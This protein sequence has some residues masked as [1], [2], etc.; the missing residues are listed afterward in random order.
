MP[1]DPEISRGASPAAAKDSGKP[2]LFGARQLDPGAIDYKNIP[3]KSDVIAGIMRLDVES[4]SCFRQ[5]DSYICSDLG[6][7]TLVLRVVNSA[8]YGHGGRIANIPKAIS[9]LGFNV[10]RSLAMLAFTRSLFA[11][12]HNPLFQL[13]IWQHSLLTALAGQ[14]LCSTLGNAYDR[15]EAFIAGLMHD[16]GKVLL[17]NHSQHR[18]LDVL[19][20]IGKGSGSIE[21]EQRLFGCDHVQVGREAVAQWKLPERF[22]DFMGNDLSTPRP[23]WKSDAVLTSLA[24]ANYLTRAN[25]IGGHPEPDVAVRKQRLMALGLD[26]IACEKWVPNA[27]IMGLME[28]DTYKLC[29]TF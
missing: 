23:E 1:V 12:T 26:D 14:T 2:R 5:L 21:A 9:V 16:M 18:Y 11:L 4:E 28:H 24:A 6:I 27:F 3:V 29:A 19:T 22:A 13:H 20:L 15:D 25:G 7:A 10:V 8:F 17:F